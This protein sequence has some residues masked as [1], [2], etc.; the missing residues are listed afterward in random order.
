MAQ[1][2]LTGFVD[3]VVHGSAATRTSAKNLIAEFTG[4]GSKR[5]NYLRFIVKGHEKGF[6]FAATENAEK[7][8]VGS[9][10]LEFDAISNAIGGVEQHT[11]AEW[12]VSLLAE[13]ANVLG[14]IIVKDFEVLLFEV[15]NQLVA[16]IQD[17]K[18]NINEIDASRN[19]GAA[20]NRRFLRG[21]R[22]WRRILGRGI[23]RGLLLGRNEKSSQESSNA[24]QSNGA[25]SHVG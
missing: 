10:L 9:V 19:A 14:S 17:S 13:E 24:N 21:S 4:I 11:D 3:S 25:V 20:L 23:L 1:F 22:W 15:G 8:I 5:L 18:K 6:V 7:E 12:Q 16:A 2:L